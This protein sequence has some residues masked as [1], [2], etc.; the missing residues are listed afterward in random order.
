[1]QR[2]RAAQKEQLQ[3]AGMLPDLNRLMLAEV[4]AGKPATPGSHQARLDAVWE[5]YTQLR[6]EIAAIQ[7]HLSESHTCSQFCV[8]MRQCP[9]CL[10]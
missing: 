5:H 6:A 3:L 1:M 10:R 4:T 7:A 9:G 2:L 8:G